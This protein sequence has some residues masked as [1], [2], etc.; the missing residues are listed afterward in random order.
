VPPARYAEAEFAQRF[1][2]LLGRAA[3]PNL[4]VGRC[5]PQGNSFFDDGDEV[6]IEDATGLPLE[7]IVA[8]HTG[9]FSDYL[10]P[11]QRFSAEYGRPV[12]RGAG[13]TFLI[14]Q[15]SSRPT[16]RPSSTASC[17][18]SASIAAAGGPLTACSITDLA[19]RPAAWPIAGR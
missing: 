6:L 11:L 2:R 19:M 3:A 13:N 15:G 18:C 14:R 16:L 17:T 7:I 9:T 10:S 5:D 12:A 1:A 4:I 8:D